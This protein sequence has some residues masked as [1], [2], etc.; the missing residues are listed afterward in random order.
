MGS[1]ESKDDLSESPKNKKVNSAMSIESFPISKDEV[2]SKATKG[3]KAESQKRNLEDIDPVLRCKVRISQVLN[4]LGNTAPDEKPQDKIPEKPQQTS[5]SSVFYGGYLTRLVSQD[6]LKA[7]KSLNKK[8]EP[9]TTNK[10]SRKRSRSRSSSS[11]ILEQRHSRS[12][13]HSRSKKLKYHHRRSRSRSSREE[14]ME[15][16]RS[17]EI[18]DDVPPTSKRKKN[19]K[20]K[21]RK[22]KSKSKEH[23]RKKR[24]HRSCSSSRQSI[25]PD[26]SV[27]APSSLELAKT[28]VK[29]KKGRKYSRRKKTP[30]TK[31][32]SHPVSQEDNLSKHIDEKSKKKEDDWQKLKQ[33]WEKKL[34]S[35]SS[36]LEK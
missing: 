35:K 22:K 3:Q 13:S 11:E 26:E 15:R 30:K 33:K 8:D 14:S 12:R 23:K 10:N 32:H 36:S 9:K 18:I 25:L 31:R 6:E 5:S 19:S 34:K 28:K 27:Q 20:F 29:L 17:I 16:S 24:K 1:M 4:K 2:R 21:E 7:F